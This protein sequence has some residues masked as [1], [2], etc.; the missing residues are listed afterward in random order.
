MPKAKHADSTLRGYRGG[1]RIKSMAVKQEKTWLRTMRTLPPDKR[2]EVFD[3]AD[4]LA[5]REEKTSNAADDLYGLWADLNI[6]ITPEDLTEARREMWS[7]FPKAR[8]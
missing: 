5:R 7:T 3:F 8:V 2:K 4:F 6:N 1:S